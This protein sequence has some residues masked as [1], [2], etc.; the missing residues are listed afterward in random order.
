MNGKVALSWWLTGEFVE[1]Q[2]ERNEGVKGHRSVLQQVCSYYKCM[3]TNKRSL[4]FTVAVRGSG[5]QSTHYFCENERE[6]AYKPVVLLLNRKTS[7]SPMYKV[8]YTRSS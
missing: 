2:T 3:Y 5:M 8:R 6:L 4:L 7:E 1:S